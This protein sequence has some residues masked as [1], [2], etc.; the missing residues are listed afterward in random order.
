V[1]GYNTAQEL[2]ALEEVGDRYSPD[3]VIVGFF[4]NDF[5]GFEPVR[6]PGVFARAASLV[7]RTMQRHVYST[8]FYKRI[9]L[10]LRYRLTESPENQQ[11]LEHLGDEDALLARPADQSAAQRLT[12]FDRLSDEEVRSFECVGAGPPLRS[13][14]AADLRKQAPW[15]KSWFDAVHGFQA[16]DREGK[17]R[18][19]FF[20]NMG[21]KECGGADRFM[22]FGTGA[23]NDALLE[24]LGRG[25]PAVSSWREFL[26]YRPSQMPA[27]AGH[28]LGNSNVVKAKVLFEFLSAGVLPPLLSS[29]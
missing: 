19:V 23:D 28:S 10:T 4:L 9:Y 13:D 3:L 14:L 8:E 17:Y 18:I 2:A 22:D 21:P 29:R 27:A 1:P 15:L 16:L 26:Y 7:M 25:T 11:R 12:P 24:I 6:H 5:T 20:I